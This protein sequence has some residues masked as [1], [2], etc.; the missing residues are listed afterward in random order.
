VETSDGSQQLTADYSRSVAWWENTSEGIQALLGRDLAPVD[1]AIV[2]SGVD[3]THQTLSGR[4]S[5]AVRVE[6]QGKNY[7]IVRAPHPANQDRHH[8][9]TA[10]A[11]IVARVAPNARIHDIRIFN[12]Q[13]NACGA[14]NVAGFRHAVEQGYSIINLSI[15]CNANHAAALQEIC[16]QA[17]RRNLLVVAAR[18][19]VPKPDMGFPAEFSSCIAVGNG[20]FDSVYTYRFTATPPIEFIA[21]GCGIEAPIANQGYTCMDGTSFAAPVISGLCALIRGAYPGI[22]PFEVKAALKAFASQD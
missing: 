14:T 2:D 4:V 1:V 9:G 11:G 18:R 13:D 20:T 12:S 8:H 7:Q 3:A 19:N 21:F 5:S 10:V 22:A 17:Y 6:F 16:E 15:V